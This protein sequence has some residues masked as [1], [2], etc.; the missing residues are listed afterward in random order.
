M[1]DLQDPVVPAKIMSI[2]PDAM[3]C[4]SEHLLCHIVSLTID[5]HVAK[6][7]DLWLI[8]SVVVVLY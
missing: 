6:V 8:L 5:L 1:S 2:R 3:F 7:G 4:F